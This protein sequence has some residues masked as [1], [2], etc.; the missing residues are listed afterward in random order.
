MESRTLVVGDRSPVTLAGLGAAGYRWSATVDDPAVVS[1]EGVT[2]E[3]GPDDRLPGASRDEGFALV[4]LAAGETIVHFAQARSF[5]PG[6]RPRATRDIH[7]RVTAADG[8][9]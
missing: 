2:L 5:E 9:N 4:A 1:V 7:V 3:R 8:K 6:S